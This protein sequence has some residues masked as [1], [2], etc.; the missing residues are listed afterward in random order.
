MDGA[1]IPLPHDSLAPLFTHIGGLLSSFPTPSPPRP[2]ISPS[3]PTSPLRRQRPPAGSLRRPLYDSCCLTVTPLP[4]LALTAVQSSCNPRSLIH[5]S[6]CGS[7]WRQGGGAGGGAGF[8]C[9]QARLECSWARPLG[10]LASYVFCS[11]SALLPC[12]ACGLFLLPVV[13]SPP[14]AS[15]GSPSSPPP[16]GLCPPSLSRAT[17]PL[18]PPPPFCDSLAKTRA[19]CIGYWSWKGGVPQSKPLISHITPS[20]AGEG[21]GPF[22]SEQPRSPDQN[23]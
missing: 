23:L 7:H 17:V 3:R 1:S 11:S 14:P 21:K 2:R 12:P 15:R 4:F 6:G 16:P 10:W 13:P 5:N 20:R 19:R 22:L 9:P 8:L 18:L